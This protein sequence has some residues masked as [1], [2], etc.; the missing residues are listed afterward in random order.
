MACAFVS[1]LAISTTALQVPSHGALAR[2]GLASHFRARSATPIALIEPSIYTECAIY[3]ADMEAKLEKL[4]Q[5]VLAAEASAQA[6]SDQM[7][8]VT[9]EKVRMEAQLTEQEARLTKLSEDLADERAE[10]GF[11]REN[12]EKQAASAAASAAAASSLEIEVSKLLRQLDD[13]GVSF[14]QQLKSETTSLKALLDDQ[15]QA[16]SKARTDALR[17][18][19]EKSLLREE[20]DARI[21]EA[22]EARRAAEQLAADLQ[23][24]QATSQNYLDAIE[25]ISRVA[26]TITSSQTVTANLT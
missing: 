4:T 8:L 17:S 7:D 22:G 20:I 24:T 26:A 10:T 19:Q 2:S 15:S 16:A 13:Q 11:L 18:E 23:A 12:L 21:I 5:A 25:E 9:Q 14:A 1:C 3:D 6:A